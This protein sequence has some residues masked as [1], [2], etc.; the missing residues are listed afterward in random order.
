MVSTMRVKEVPPLPLKVII[1]DT[2]THELHK[3]TH[4]TINLVLEER[5]KVIEQ[6]KNDPENHLE[7]EYRMDFEKYFGTFELH[8]SRVV[9]KKK[10]A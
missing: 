7:E 1:E 3:F 10:R 6:A 2:V 5:E 8:T 4:S 9:K